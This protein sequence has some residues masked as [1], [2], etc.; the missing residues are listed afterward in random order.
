MRQSARTIRGAGRYIAVAVIAGVLL[1]AAGFHSMNLASGPRA[2]SVDQ[3]GLGGRES[4]STVELAATVP[5]TQPVRSL[6]D[7]LTPRLLASQPIQAVALPA[8]STA[9]TANLTAWKLSSARVRA[10]GTTADSSEGELVHDRVFE[11]VATSEQGETARFTVS[12]SQFTASDDAPVGTTPGTYYLRGSWRLVPGTDA[13]GG[14]PALKGTLSAYSTHEMLASEDTVQADL[15][16]LGAYA[17]G[18]ITART[19]VYSGT[20]AFEGTLWL[21]IAQ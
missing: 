13:N 10:K 5:D 14:P 1:I 6:V 18:A 20:A 12:L 11:A 2:R 7:R 15:A 3:P 4:A 8:H 17:P 19:G 21:P 9:A 16:L